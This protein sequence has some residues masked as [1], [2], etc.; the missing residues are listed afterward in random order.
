M[1][2]IYKIL[3][4]LENRRVPYCLQAQKNYYNISVEDPKGKSQN[5]GSADLGNVEVFLKT[6]W[7]HLLVHTPVTAIPMPRPF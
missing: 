1:R 7:G 6:M 5:Y 2:D 3:H 4:E